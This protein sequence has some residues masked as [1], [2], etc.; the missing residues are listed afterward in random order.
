MIAA[1][2]AQQRSK[3]SNGSRSMLFGDQRTAGARRF[4]DL[5]KDFADEVGGHAHLAVSG[6]QLV[7]R[8]AQ[9]SIELEL[10]EAQRASGAAIDPVGFV[11]LVNLQRRLLRDLERLKAA[12]KPSQP[13]LAEHLARRFPPAAA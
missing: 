8:I 12:N 1:Q 9:V 3:V 5:Q 13:S 6:Q 10:L 4:R 7:R 2:A 11:K